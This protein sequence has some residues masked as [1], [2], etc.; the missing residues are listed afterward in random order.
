MLFVDK[1]NMTPAERAV[2][3]GEMD[4]ARL[5]IG[6]SNSPHLSVSEFIS[7]VNKADEID[8]ISYFDLC[9][10]DLN[11]EEFMSGLKS[12]VDSKKPRRPKL[13]LVKK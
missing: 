10:K 5:A 3:D 2:F 1:S 4:G 13:T 7:F 9:D 6:V 8:S 11:D 12:I